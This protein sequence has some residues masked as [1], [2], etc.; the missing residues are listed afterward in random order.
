[1]AALRRATAA[2]QAE[3][4]T[5]RRRLA[6]VERRAADESGQADRANDERAS[7]EAQLAGA[8]EVLTAA[9]EAEAGAAARRERARERASATEAEHATAHER[10]VAASASA[11][12]MRAQLDGLEARL[13]DEETRGIARAARRAG[14]RRLDEDL[15]IDPTLRAATEAALA[16]ATRAYVVAADAVPTL[17]TERGSLLVTERAAGPI[18]PEDARDRRYREAI[19]AAGGGTLD[20]AVRRDTTGVARRLLMRAAWLPDLAACLAVQA[21]MPPGWIAVTRDGSAIVTDIGVTFGSSES[22]LERRAVPASTDARSRPSMRKWAPSRSRS[23][24][25]TVAK[26]TADGQGRAPRRAGPRAHDERQRK[27]NAGG[28]GSR[29]SSG[30]HPGT[31]RS[32]RLAAELGRARAVWQCSTPTARRR[33]R[34]PTRPDLTTRAGT[35]IVAWG[36]RRGCA[37]AGTGLPRRA[38]RD[39]TRRDAENQRVRA[40]ASTA[41]EQRM[42]RRCR[43]ARANASAPGRGA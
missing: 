13:A 27:P 24:M 42:A 14:G 9:I 26:A 43:R 22:V 36:P 16:E 2:R 23:Q 35:A 19:A 28:A 18:G 21:A 32:P 39:A 7:L 4:E 12:A 8:R 17:A 29:R 3:V 10:A 20:E 11:A 1:M 38:A 31:R 41:L 34:A 40:E 15:D 5:A 6:E 30:R 37:H 33:P 25:A